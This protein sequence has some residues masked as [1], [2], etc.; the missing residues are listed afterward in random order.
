MKVQGR[1]IE[2]DEVP[3]IYRVVPAS[4]GSNGLQ[5]DIVDP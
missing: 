3:G 2:L 5:A 4:I 1:L